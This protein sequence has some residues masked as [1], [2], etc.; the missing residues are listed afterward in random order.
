MAEKD[1]A[2]LIEEMSN[3]LHAEILETSNS[4]RA[5]FREAADRIEAA[6]RRHS[7]MITSGAIAIGTMNRS[8]ARHD[9]EI[10][11]LKMRLRAVERRLPK[12]RKAS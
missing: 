4:L 12:R 3:S 9:K 2:R 1:L 8:L 11:Q 5:E 6:S 7:G 10:A